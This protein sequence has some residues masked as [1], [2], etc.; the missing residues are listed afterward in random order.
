MLT[1]DQELVLL[2]VEAFAQRM[3]VLP[4]EQAVVL[5]A[6]AA[7]Y[8]EL[9]YLRSELVGVKCSF[10]EE[11]LLGWLDRAVSEA[12]WLSARPSEYDAVRLEEKLWYTLEEVPLHL[13]KLLDRWAMVGRGELPLREDLRGVIPPFLGALP[14]DKL[15]P[16]VQF[17]R[18]E[19]EWLQ[20]YWESERRQAY[21]HLRETA[22]ALLARLAAYR[23]EEK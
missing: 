8:S 6:P 2:Q 9:L 21:E 13:A 23:E 14:L 18:D 1:A 19:E 12:Y 17:Y 3:K 11:P 15:L 5:K 20:P 10:A 16:L 7:A 4:Q 22:S